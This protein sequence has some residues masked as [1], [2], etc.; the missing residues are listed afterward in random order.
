MLARDETGYVLMDFESNILR[1]YSHAYDH[2]SPFD[3]MGRAVFSSNG[4][5]GVITEKESLVLPPIFRKIDFC[6][7]RN[8]T[9]VM[10]H[11]E[12]NGNYNV[13]DAF[14]LDF[15][16]KGK[17]RTIRRYESPSDSVGCI[18]NILVAKEC[19]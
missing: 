18:T 7:G 14:L 15:V 9:I 5:C 4:M 19:C 12:E 11:D 17:K 6:I 1:S 10:C 3:E 2:L 16:V 8:K 13:Y